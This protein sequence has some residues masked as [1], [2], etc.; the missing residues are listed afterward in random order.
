MV[1]WW[2][3]PLHRGADDYD[4]YLFDSAGDVTNFSQ[5]VQ[6]GTQDPFE[7]L[8]TTGEDDLRV[9]VVKFS[10]ARRGTS[11]SPHSAAGSPTPPTGSRRGRRPA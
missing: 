7:I 9:A 10:G 11:S 5:D 6:N 2:A 3:D 8:G 4:L 1:L